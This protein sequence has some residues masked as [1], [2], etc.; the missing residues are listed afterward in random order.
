MARRVDGATSFQID[1]AN[2]VKPDAQ[3]VLVGECEIGNDPAI[4]PKK[5]CH[6]AAHAFERNGAVDRQIRR[7]KAPPTHVGHL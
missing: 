4:T 7:H 3:Y 5:R 1:P 2:P 6:I